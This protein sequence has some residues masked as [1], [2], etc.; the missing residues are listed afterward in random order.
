MGLSPVA[1]KKPCQ[2]ID[3]IVHCA[4]TVQ[5]NENLEQSLAFNTLSLEHVADLSRQSSWSP[6]LHVS[7]CYVNGLH[8]GRIAENH[9]EPAGKMPMGLA[10]RN[11]DVP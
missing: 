2:R 10:S 9:R 6:V 4:A 7:T 11:P 8:E 3:L 1:C 5:F